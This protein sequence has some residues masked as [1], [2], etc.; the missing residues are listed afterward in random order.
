MLKRKVLIPGVI[1]LVVLLAGCLLVW[2]AGFFSHLRISKEKCVA[3]FTTPEN[4]IVVTVGT[5]H[6][7]HYDK[8]VGYSITD[9]YSLLRYVHP[10]YVF[11]ECRPETFEQYG[12]LDGPSEML[13]IYSFCKEKN[14]PVRC[15]DWW[16]EDNN[17]KANTTT[18]ERDDRIFGNICENLAAVPA[19]K[20][21]MIFYG[22][23]HFYDQQPRMKASGWQPV[24]FGNPEG[25]FYYADKEF[26][27]P[28]GFAA[29]LEKKIQYNLSVE[30]QIIDETITDQKVHDAFYQNVLDLCEWERTVKNMVLQNHLNK[31]AE[32]WNLRV[33]TSW[34]LILFN[35]RCFFHFNSRRFFHIRKK[36]FFADFIILRKRCK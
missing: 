17:A 20:K 35:N 21:V 6:R 5:I 13:Y 32:F 36:I 26:Q 14:I 33:F 30:L 10:E 18:T 2:G 3:S 16:Q 31:G 23:K 34:G 22:T 19:D 4:Q 8:R 24:V 27:Y 11:I 9:I 29:E 12:A 1:A 28:A 25:Y 15:I 7:N